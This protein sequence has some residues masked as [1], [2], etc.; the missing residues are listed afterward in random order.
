M[1]NTMSE[2]QLVNLCLSLLNIA[3]HYCWRNN[4]GFFKHDYTTKA[5][6]NKR[7]VIRTGV[8]GAS[9]ILG[10]AKDG[11]FIAVECKVKNNKPTIHQKL[12]LDEI[13]K[14]GGYSIVAYDVSDLQT[15][16]GEGVNL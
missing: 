8:T 3:G 13:K 11:K 14:R 6:I 10:I 1:Q 7:S 16:I 9:D 12:F 15:L 2:T 5:G 4:S